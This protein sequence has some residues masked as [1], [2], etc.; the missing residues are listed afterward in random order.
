MT[1]GV[2]PPVNL[3]WFD[4]V[5][6]TVALSERTMNAWPAADS[7]P[8]PETLLVAGAQTRGR[9]R[10]AHAWSSP[11]GGLY[12]NWL[13]WLPAAQVGQVPLAVGATLAVAAES[14]LPGLAIGLKWP[15]DLQVGGRKLGGVLCHSRGGGDRAWASVGFGIN[16][17]VAPP[18][19]D[20]DARPVSLREL[21]LS[22]PPG[23]AIDAIVAAFLA[24]IHAALADPIGTRERWLARSV[25]RPG[26]AMRLRLDREVVDGRFVGF[27][28][29]GRVELEVGGELM[30][31]SV[32]EVVAGTGAGG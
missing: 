23:Q 7:A 5:D 16:V 1:A 29:D 19:E 2:P 28:A 15:N 12:A 20:G 11:P 8:L 13:V 10:G 18:V 26:D 6:S 9:G 30:R 27:D 25:H 17:A 4:E 3:V 31:Y 14:V 24:R 22:S 32:G 21:G